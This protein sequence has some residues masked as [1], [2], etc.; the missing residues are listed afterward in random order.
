MHLLQMGTADISQETKRVLRIEILFQHQNPF[1]L[2]L[3]KQY[4]ERK[5][6]LV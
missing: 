6:L 1:Q 4:G 2:V 5:V 3:I